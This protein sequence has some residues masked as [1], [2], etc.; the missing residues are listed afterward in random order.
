MLN[1]LFNVS[2][3]ST[4]FKLRHGLLKFLY[5]VFNCFDFHRLLFK[6]KSLSVKLDKIVNQL[7]G[8]L[9]I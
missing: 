2:E 7:V 6:Q 3:L 9:D 8:S 4:L 5:F 1:V